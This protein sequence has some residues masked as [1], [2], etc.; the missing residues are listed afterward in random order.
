MKLI[1]SVFCFAIFFFSKHYTAMETK[2]KPT[3]KDTIM[4]AMQKTFAQTCEVECTSEKSQNFNF[5]HIIEHGNV[6]DL[7]EVVSKIGG[8][9]KLLEDYPNLL[10]YAT[11]QQKLTIFKHLIAN[12]YS[13]D[14]YVPESKMPIYEFIIYMKSTP[15][16]DRMLRIAYDTSENMLEDYYR[17]MFKKSGW[18]ADAAT[19]M[20][21]N[22]FI[23][24]DRILNRH[25]AN[26]ENVII[27]QGLM[28]HSAVLNDCPMCVKLILEAGADP[29]FPYVG[30][31]LLQDE[32]TNEKKSIEDWTPLMIAVAKGNDRVID[33]LLES[34][35][36]QVAKGV[37]ED[38]LFTAR[39]IARQQ[40]RNERKFELL[41]KLRA[42]PADRPILQSWVKGVA[43]EHLNMKFALR[44]HN[45]KWVEFILHNVDKKFDAEWLKFAV[46]NSNVECLEI[47]IKE[48]PKSLK[49][50]KLIEA[51]SS[52]DAEYERKCEVIQ[53]NQ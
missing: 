18:Q 17:P 31:A 3:L 38:D 51:L 26:P 9:G 52:S 16:R 20:K 34:P 25:K 39:E 45:K 15:I 8:Y 6:D 53:S 27:D 10:Y 33:A 47:L 11:L 48:Y 29:N 23:Y 41:N 12:G 4:T 46:E 49:E 37:P 7:D 36:I 35:K 1:I 43:L 30:L 50:L 44:R 28:I 14:S 21:R 24:I 2:V 13:V 42:R 32:Y 19:A 22:D 5:L 40:P